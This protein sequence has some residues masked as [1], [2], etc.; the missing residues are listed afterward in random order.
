MNAHGFNESL[1]KNILL[2][3]VKEEVPRDSLK[4]VLEIRQSWSDQLVELSKK[5]RPEPL[6]LV[7]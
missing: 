7:K 5:N 1:Y 4:N 2:E 6:E 3:K